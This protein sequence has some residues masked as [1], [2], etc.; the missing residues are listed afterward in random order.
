MENYESLF[1]K[2]FDK[3]SKFNFVKGFL[4]NLLVIIT[5]QLYCNLILYCCNFATKKSFSFINWS[6][7]ELLKIFSN[8]L[9]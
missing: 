9:I 5:W 3:G 6:S 2:V 8:P 7:F 1:A 4:V